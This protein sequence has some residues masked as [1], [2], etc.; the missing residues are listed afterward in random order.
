MNAH[1][2]ISPEQLEQ[3]MDM[4]RFGW[5]KADFHT[6]SYLCSDYLSKLLCLDSDTISFRD[7]QQM[8]RPDHRDRIT[9][10]FI[11][12]KNE[13]IY[14]Q[15]FP[16]CT[17]R[18]ETWIHSKLGKKETDPDGHLT[19]WGFIQC[20]TNPQ[21]IKTEKALEKFNAHLHQQN[22][23]S[24]SLLSFLQTE[25]T[26]E[27]IHKILENLL[28]QYHA[29]RTY[30]IEYDWKNNVQNCS[31]EVNAK[32]VTP[33]QQNI[34]RLPIGETPW[35]TQQITSHTPIILFN[36][37]ELPPEAQ[38]EKQFLSMQGIKSIM[39][40][41]MIAQDKVWGY[42]GIDILDQNRDWRHEDYQW[43]AT[44]GNIISICMELHRAKNKAL[45]EQEYFKNL[46]E[47]MPIG[48]IRIRLLYDAS[49]T[50]CDYLL[51]DLNPAFEKITGSKVEDFLGKTARQLKLP[52][53]IDKQVK[54]LLEIEQQGTF[55]QV[56]FKASDKNQYFRCIV[57]S[58]EK[59]ETVVLFS[60]FTDIQKAHEA[61][62]RSEKELRNIYRN[63][64]VG[65]E[66]YDKEG[67]L[68]DMND[69]DMEIFGLKDKT[70]AIGVNLFENPNV[71]E[72]VKQQLRQQKNMDFRIKYNFLEI[73]GYYQSMQK[74]VKDL[75]V[76]VSILYNSQNEVENYMLIII[77][78]TET[79]TAYSK[80]Q[81]F[82]NFFSVIA[83]FAKVG[84][85][86]WNPCTSTGFALDQWF[87]NWGE[88]EDAYLGNVVGH[89]NQTHPDDQAKLLGLYSG[90][91]TGQRN[92]TKEEIRVKDG[93]GG[94][95]WIRSTV[96]VT[97]YEPEHNDIELIGVN[98]DITELKEIEAK[99]IEAKNKAETLDKL[100]SAF[101]AN[102]SHEIRTPL[103]AI[104]GF[105]SLLTETQ[106]L[107]EQKQYISII[108]ENNDLL[109]QLISDIL[110]LS[111]IE[112]G[113]FEM[114]YGDVDVYLLCSEIVRTLS[115]K[116]GPNVALELEHFQPECHM[117][118]D[119]NRLMQ[120]ITNFINNALKFTAQGSVRLGYY[121]Y[122]KDI[123]FYVSDT[124]IGIPANHLHSVFE[125]FVKLNS[126]IH[127]T[128]LGLSICKSMVEQMGGHIGVESEEG[129][130]S[131]FWFRVPLNTPES[132]PCV[133]I[134]PKETAA[135]S[136]KPK[137]K[138]VLLVAEDTESNF[139]L[140]STILKKEYTILW[141]QTGVETLQLYHQNH[142]DLII[143]DVRMPEM[144][145]L[146]A[147]R[148]IR[149]QDTQTPIIALTAFAFDSDKSKT[150]QAGCN[151][152][153]SKPVN[154]QELKNTIKQLLNQ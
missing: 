2:K 69:K 107:E 120:I 151:A 127:G 77:D 20:I 93:K 7:F 88:P 37:D 134:S 100:K 85:F 83:D 76:K 92:G 23:I 51:T 53:N 154:A 116:A 84:Y 147:T 64:P 54:D 67:Y 30:I 86:K 62:N 57:Y 111:K 136:A 97:K 119:R 73:D 82:E 42:M 43:F 71:P 16:I 36:L 118:G 78:N 117:L 108:Q 50:P 99:L 81:E 104:V 133:T 152:Y 149:E 39:V 33:Q 46:Y 143:M 13:Q 144:D 49:G 11:S 135:T 6:Q 137:T 106:D 150:M 44:L 90:L 56:N 114:T 28:E 74:G 25:N 103:N 140:I 21:E 122:G 101:L 59:G 65:I 35:W 129:K 75:I 45:K 34:Y 87:K 60:D 68:K 15:T 10:E 9:Q 89:Y 153:L 96:L 142:P 79:S 19:A 17:E 145:G 22:N 55:S 128:G 5:W 123:E 139:I 109:L 14:E 61:L 110:D 32:G 52:F 66:I 91:L 113:T 4:A 102:M 18:G 124:G 130:G 3:L 29:G 146:E 47:Y 126:F 38:A 31:F 41:P 98:F 115:L 112:A 8:I 141:V 95:K 63:I 70:D 40:I 58:P 27:V 148:K 24:R 80:I 48:Y 131:R 132:A 121:I 138:P 72:E 1:K 26:G 94:W 125:R 12:I 105:S